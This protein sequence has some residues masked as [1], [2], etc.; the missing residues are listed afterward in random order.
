MDSLNGTRRAALVIAH[1]GHELRVY[2]WLEAARPRVFVLTDGSGRT[3][4]SR[5]KSTVNI[6]EGVGARPGSIFGRFTDQAVYQ[7]TLGHD[8][9]LFKVFARELA[10]EFVREHVDY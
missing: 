3:G 4:H 6:L 10:D 2:G 9:A 8:H 7:A 5:L 1:P